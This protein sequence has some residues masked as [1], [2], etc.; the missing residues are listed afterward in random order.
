[1][2]PSNNDNEKVVS[3]R[4][5]TPPSW[6]LYPAEKHTWKLHFK[7]GGVGPLADTT[8]SLSFL[9]LAS[10]YISPEIQITIHPLST[11]GTIIIWVHVFVETFIIE[12]EIW[13]QIC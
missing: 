2:L 4:G 9:V 13:P 12:T 5:P 11:D 6:K 8:F 3:A 10:S 7:I 1:M